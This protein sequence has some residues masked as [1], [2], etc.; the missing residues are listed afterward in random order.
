VTSWWHSANPRSRE[1]ARLHIQGQ[2]RE[3]GRNEI[4]A[5]LNC[6][7]IASDRNSFDTQHD[8]YREDAVINYPQSDEHIK[9]RRNIPAS[10]VAQA[11][12]KRFSVF[13]GIGTGDLWAAEF[14]ITYDGKPSHSGSGTE[15]LD[16]RVA[17]ATQYFVRA[18]AL[19]RPF[20]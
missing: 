2:G 13:R 5:A 1:A 15:F 6:H 4:R 20:G 3:H 10:R 19:V 14:T 16:G 12:S 11:T 9:G 18:R 7:R 8:K 17:R